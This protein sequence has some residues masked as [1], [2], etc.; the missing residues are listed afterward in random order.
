MFDTKI[1]IVVREDLLDWQKLNMTA[2]LASGLIGSEE[3]ILGDPYVDADQNHYNPLVV[4]PMIVLAA[5][6]D[7]LPTIYDRG[8]RRELRMSLFIDDMF[9]TGH[10]AANRAAVAKYPAEDLPLAGLAFRGAKNVVDKVTK[11][12]RMHP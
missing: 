9:S 4:Q 12:A 7:L 6:S 3:D 1:A 2:F 5:A 11:G 10:D 8:M